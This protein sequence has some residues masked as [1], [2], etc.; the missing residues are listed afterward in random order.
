MH[1]LDFSINEIEFYKIR[2][3]LIMWTDYEFGNELIY[4]RFLRSQKTHVGKIYAYRYMYV[5]RVQLHRYF[6]N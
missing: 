5:Y 2:Y 3:T 4:A 1:N 6:E